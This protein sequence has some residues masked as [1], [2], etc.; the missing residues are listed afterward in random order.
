MVDDGGGAIALLDGG[1]N[2]IVNNACDMSASVAHGL[3]VFPNACR[4][5]FQFFKG[6]CF[7]ALDPTAKYWWDNVKYNSVAEWESAGA[8]TGN[9]DSVP[10]F[11]SPDS[12]DLHL[13]PGSAC[14]DH[15]SPDSAAG[16]D[17]DGVLRPQGAGF[18]IGA[19]EYVGV[20]TRETMSDGRRT[21]KV[22]PTI[23]R[24]VL[25][26]NGDCPRTGTVPKA[27]LLDALG[28]KVIE[29]R[30][31]ANDVRRLSPGVYFAREVSGVRRIVVLG[32][33]RD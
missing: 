3:A 33:V 21:G 4:D 31:G 14:I 7:Y 6:N 8:Q 18:D 28:R 25:F 30:P 1:H 13:A 2:T 32:P 16:D 29:L 24:G 23:I 26:L 19:F 27:A 5:S 10:G 11:T 17:F 12:E 15:G 22:G 9:I 20:G